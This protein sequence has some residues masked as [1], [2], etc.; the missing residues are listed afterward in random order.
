MRQK[1]RNPVVLTTFLSLFAPVA[2]GGL[3]IA[4]GDAALRSDLHTLADA[5]VIVAPLSS[6]PIAWDDIAAAVGSTPSAELAPDVLDAYARVR[7][8]SQSAARSGTVRMHG[9]IALA[10]SPRIIRNFEATPRD[11]AEIGGGFQWTG[12]RFAVRLDATRVSRPADG[13]SVRLDGSYIGATVGNWILTVGYPER[14]WGPGWD[15]NLILTTNA[16]P[17]PQIAINRNSARP[18]SP[19][20]LRWLGPWTVSSFLGVMD[21]ERERDDPLFFGLRFAS[22]PLPGLELGVS[23]TAQWCGEGRPCNAEA[24]WNLMVGRSNRGVNVPIDKEPGNQLAGFDMRWSPAFWR[25]PAAFYAQWIGEDSRQGGPQIG[26]WLRQV[27]IEFA[28]AV[29]ESGWRHRTYF[30]I[31]ETICREGGIGFSVRKYNCAYDHPLYM[32]GYRYQGRSV[33]HGMD[34]DGLALAFSTLL[35]DDAERSWQFALRRSEIKRGGQPNPEHTLSP[36]PQRIVEFAVTRSRRI[37]AG[38]LNASVGYRRIN[39]VVDRSRNEGST[40]GWLEYVIR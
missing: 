40:T 5:G 25:V 29:G 21:D 17:T 7:R 24:F 22:R 34:G 8:H 31:S 23:R 14:W 13:D 9:R 16:R 28:G 33:A 11:R 20:W 36:V 27:G 6:W 12:D 1:L 38:T 15:G 39:D 30:E 35:I 19:G 3:W 4:P 37:G 18:F 10:E 26:S 2:A 32:P